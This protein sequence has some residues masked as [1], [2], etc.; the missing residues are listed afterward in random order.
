MNENSVFLLTF[1]NYRMRTNSRGTRRKGLEYDTR[2]LEDG[3]N[4]M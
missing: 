3:S 4:L 2:D 1:E